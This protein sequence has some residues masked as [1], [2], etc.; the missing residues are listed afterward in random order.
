MDGTSWWK[1]DLM[2]AKGIVVEAVRR[3]AA[4]FSVD[5]W[6]GRGILVMGVMADMVI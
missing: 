2:V 1:R 6:L 5:M 3:V 4:V